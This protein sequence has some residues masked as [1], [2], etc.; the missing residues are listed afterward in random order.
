MATLDRAFIDD[1]LSRINIVEVI[2]NSVK[3]K[4]LGTNYK[5]LCPFHSENT[6]SFNVSET[7]QFY[8]C[9]GCGASGDV[10]KFLRESEGLSFMD[11]IEKLANI[12]NIEIPKNNKKFEDDTSHL[13]NINK[14]AHKYFLNSLLKSKSA[15]EYLNNRGIEDTIIKKFEIG[16]A[17]ESWDNLKTIIEKEG[18]IKDAIDLGLLVKNK[19][20]VYDRFRNRIMFPIKNSSGK[21]IAYGGRTLDKNEKAKY[22]NSPE[23]KLFY[24][25]A[26]MYG[27]FESKQSINK[28]DMVIVVEGY[29]DVVSLHKHGFENT[30]A[31]LGTALTKLHLKKLKRYSK[32]IIFCFDGDQA[33]KNAA[34]K[35]LLNC[36]PEITDE[37]NIGFCFIEDEKDPD[38]LCNESPEKFENIINNKIPLSDFIFNNVMQNLDLNKIEDKTKL[39]RI[40]IPLIQQIPD[41]IYKKLLQDKLCSLTN[42]STDE[43]FTNNEKKE[44]YKE[45]DKSAYTVRLDTTILSI[46]LEYPSLYEEFKTKINNIIQD[47]NIRDMISI[48][49]TLKTN[50]KYMLNNFLDMD[51]TKKELFIKY[52][53]TKSIE[54]NIDEAKK[55]IE[56]ILDEQNLAK[57]DIKFN[58]ILEKWKRKEVLSEEERKVL[59]A[60]NKSKKL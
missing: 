35:A 53:S 52:T 28:K 59:K 46:L 55:T 14:I 50:N 45:Q 29:T 33:G 49:P 44:V 37:T 16:Y 34:W 2:G 47:K 20:K 8:H 10:I 23:S 22:I 56:L 48:I 13:L 17:E 1:L 57:E 21:V 43:L 26:E 24:K 30:V 40:I 31:S 7:K 42:L 32:N 15:R 51:D 3:L 54:K 9:F 58:K 25:S 38:E 11:A 4:K 19:N 12:A 60:G 41:G 36:L 18:K 27:V 39:I 6:P 5:G